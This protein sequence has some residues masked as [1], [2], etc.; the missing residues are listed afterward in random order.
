MAAGT[1]QQISDHGDQYGQLLETASYLSGLWEDRD[2]PSLAPPVPMGMLIIEDRVLSAVLSRLVSD[3]RPYHFDHLDLEVVAGVLE[4]YLTRTV[5]RSAAH[6]VTVVDTHDTVLSRGRTSPPLHVIRYMATTSLDGARLNRSPRDVLPLRVLDP[7]CGAGT[8][9]L[10]I[11]R[12]LLVSGGGNRLTLDE[13]HTILVDSLYG[14]DISRQAVA[15]TKMLLLFRLFEVCTPS[16]VPQDVPGITERVLRDL[17]HTVRCGNALIAPDI[18]KDESWMFCPVRERHT[19]NPFAWPGEFPEI[20]A[21]GG[22]DAMI[23][24]PPE[25][26]PEQKEWIQR[27]LQRHYAVYDPE[28]DL[29]AFF[30]EKGLVLLR[31]GGTLCFSMSDRWF[32]GR[33]GSPLRSLLTTNQIEEIVDLPGSGG[34]LDEKGINILRLI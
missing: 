6:Q 13:C 29:S 33:A 15:V 30:V 24:N 25:G 4:H 18:V 11:F 3:D 32:R 19:L 31:P 1:L 23:S 12:A 34:V 5:R 8:V 7:S 20:F 17:R 9:L 26:L 27:Y 14:V 10:C 22:F 28:V 21:A 16:Q 2:N